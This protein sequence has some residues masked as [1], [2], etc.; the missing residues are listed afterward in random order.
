MKQVLIN[1][2]YG[3][4]ELSPFG[5]ELLG[6]DSLNDL[7]RD[8]SRLISAFIEHGNRIASSF[9]EFRLVTISD[10]DYD[11]HDD[12]EFRIFDYDGIESVVSGYNL[13][14]YR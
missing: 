14:I 2:C 8:D 1:R 11:N 3:G 13:K 10:D 12:I 4:A 9:S 5:K 7:E 6:V